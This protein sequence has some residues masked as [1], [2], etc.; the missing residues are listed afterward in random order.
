M[1]T[2]V[3][4]GH[5]GRPLQMGAVAWLCFGLLQ[6]VALLRIRADWAAMCTCGSV[7]TTPALAVAF[8]YHGCCIS[9]HL[10][11]SAGGRQ[12]GLNGARAA[13]RWRSAAP[14]SSG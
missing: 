14:T 10:P 6:L 4:M 5:S 8:L 7:I 11:D 9:H 12:A 13:A 3:T 1:V 2:R